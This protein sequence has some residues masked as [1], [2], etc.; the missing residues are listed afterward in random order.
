MKAKKHLTLIYTDKNKQNIK[1]NIRR[2]F[3]RIRTN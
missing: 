3:A 1:E 2:G